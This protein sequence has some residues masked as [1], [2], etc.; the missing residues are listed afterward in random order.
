MSVTCIYRYV[1]CEM[2]VLFNIFK[3]ILSVFCKITIDLLYFLSSLTLL[4]LGWGKFTPSPKL[5]FI[6]FFNLRFLCEPIFVRNIVLKSFFDTLSRFGSINH[7]SQAVGAIKLT[8][9]MHNF[10]VLCLYIFLYYCFCITGLEISE[11]YLL[12]K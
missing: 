10:L 4:R 2:N 12:R 6:T 11:V 7:P 9:F 8:F 1:C 3:I 5:F